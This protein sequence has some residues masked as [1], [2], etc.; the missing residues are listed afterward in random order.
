MTN[1]KNHVKVA[2]RRLMNYRIK[3][4]DGTMVD[5]PTEEDL[6]GA[7]LHAKRTGGNLSIGM[8]DGGE[9]IMNP[10]HIVSIHAQKPV[11]KATKEEGETQ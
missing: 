6:E 3:L 2:Q 11:V 5:F 10:D 4:T 1:E 8:S 7:F 9:F